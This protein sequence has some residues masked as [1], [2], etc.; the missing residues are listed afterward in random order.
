[1]T[2]YFSLFHL[3]EQASAK[4]IFT[5]TITVALLLNLSLPLESFCR[6]PPTQKPYVVDRITYFPIP[7]SKG[8]IERGT[9]SWYGPDFHGRPTSNGERYDMFQM[10]AAHKTLPMNTVLLVQNLDNKREVVVRINDRGPFV[11]G[12]V[13]DLS[14]KAAK[15][16]DM[17]G[18]GTAKVRIVAM[19]RE[20]ALA[21]NGKGP[22]LPDLRHGEFY[23]QI[24]SFSRRQNAI[25]L[26]K[27]F[28]NAGHT[29][30]IQKYFGPGKVFYRVQ[31]YAGKEL[32]KARRSEKALLRLGYT[33]A[34]VVAR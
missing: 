15:Q 24:G 13:I 18:K 31:L 12:R 7:T 21:Q 30:V 2:G 33:G 17:V 19:A 20:S 32:G 8:Y 10:T 14:Y 16:L 4:K 26:Q 25:N 29:T 3:G 23:I 28:T 9:A 27:R 1:M 22:G 11:R 5:L 6:I 34:F